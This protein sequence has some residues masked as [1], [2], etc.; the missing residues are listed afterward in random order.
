M[1]MLAA[2]T[3]GCTPSKKGGK[4]TETTETTYYKQKNKQRDKAYCWP[5]FPPDA[6]IYKS[7]DVEKQHRYKQFFSFNSKEIEVVM[8]NS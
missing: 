3:Y 6:N 5:A 2:V 4:V 7:R 1:A 8:L